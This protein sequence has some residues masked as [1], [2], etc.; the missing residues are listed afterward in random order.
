[1]AGIDGYDCEGVLTIGGVSF[2]NPAWAC[3]SNDRGENGLI[4]LLGLGADRKGADREIPHGIGGIA[5]PRRR[6]PTRYDLGMLICGDVNSAGVENADA[7]AGLV[8]NVLALETVIDNVA[9]GASGLQAA[10]LAIGG[11]NLAANIHTLA[12]QVEWAIRQ[13]HTNQALISATL[14]ISIPVGKFA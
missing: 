13:D 11:Q 6:R 3:V 4:Q 14:Q 1:M 5:Y 8:T 12:I 2:N 7:W 10:T 9:D